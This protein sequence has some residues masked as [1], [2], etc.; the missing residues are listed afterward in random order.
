MVN[1]LFNFTL[2]SH[3]GE[4]NSI[5]SILSSVL[6]ESDWILSSRVKLLVGDMCK[7]TDEIEEDDS[8][9]MSE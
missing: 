6:E 9:M 1:W 5:S 2:F 7:D 8:D 4:K 3:L